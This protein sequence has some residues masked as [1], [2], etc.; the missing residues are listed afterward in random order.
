MKLNELQVPK[1][2]TSKPTKRLGRGPATGQGGTA[3]KG[4]KGQNSRSGGGVRRSFEGG[5]MPLIR[6]L[7]KKGFFNLF[8]TEYTVVNL[9][10]INN[11]GLEGE[12]TPEIL[13]AS[14][15]IKKS[16]KNVKILGM[17]EI[18]NALN[19]K[20]HAFSKSA[21]EKIEKAGGKI[22]EI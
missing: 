18:K 8:R 22:E 13:A 10:D 17:G 5:Q 1:K 14:G 7:P 9:S 11:K 2:A 6:R 20:A 12:I 3:G 16:D 21:R 15:L 4:H 19:I